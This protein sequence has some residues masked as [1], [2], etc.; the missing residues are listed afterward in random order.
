MARLNLQDAAFLQVETAECPAHVAGLQIFKLPKNYKGNF[1]RE[2]MMRIDQS[3]PPAPPFNMKLKSASLSLDVLPAW[4]EDKNFDLDYH[5]RYSALPAPGSMDQLMKL[6]E[7]LHSR[8]LDRTRPLW[9]CYYIEG[10]ENRQVALYFKI[11]HSCVDGVAAMSILD[12]VMSKTRNSKKVVGFW[13]VPPAH[14]ESAERPKLMDRLT[15]TY[16]GFLGQ[17]RSVQQLSGTALKSGL[18]AIS[19]T[20][21]KSPMPFTAPATI[22]NQSI[23]QHRRFATHTIPLSRIKGIAKDLDLTVNDVV[24]GICSGAIRRYLKDRGQLPADKPILAMCPVSVRPKDAEQRGN[25]ISM[26]V[27]TLATNE[28]DTIARLKLIHDSA[29]EAKHKLGELAREASTNYALLMNGVILL[30]QAL[31]LGNMV[32]PPANLVISNVPGPREKLYL[33]GAELVH[34]Y[35]MSVLVH[36][37]ALNITVTSYA[38]ELDFGLLGAREIMPDLDKLAGYI[39]TACNE[40]EIADEAH[41]AGEAEAARQRLAERRTARD[42]APVAKPKKAKSARKSNGHATGQMAP[43]S[44][45]ISAMKE[46]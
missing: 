18:Q 9:E 6:V 27:T 12:R 44:A 28:N 42:T 37:Q 34:N 26:I 22:F 5:V 32:A 10:L 46:N 17:A 35:P 38:D 29:S 39:A 8:L 3:V 1:F 7:R 30:S 24:L 11:H 43:M 16:S 40:I 14:R 41:L 15:R 25:Q 45:D 20:P 2:M 13:Q 4:V 31:G 23:T 19:G 36:G 21:R 33:M